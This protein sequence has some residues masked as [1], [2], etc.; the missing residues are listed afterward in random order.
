L[1]QVKL[2]SQA[3]QQLAAEGKITRPQA[4][5]REYWPEA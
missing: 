2:S 3:A 5:W 4:D 1:R